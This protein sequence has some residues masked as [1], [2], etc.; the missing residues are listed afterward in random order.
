MQ[1]IMKDCRPVPDRVQAIF[2][3]WKDS[4]PAMIPHSA[5]PDQVFLDQKARIARRRA[6]SRRRSSSF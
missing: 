6:L 2:Y 4:A 1:L 5:Y 3:G